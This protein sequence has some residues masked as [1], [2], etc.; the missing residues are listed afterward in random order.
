MMMVPMMMPPQPPMSPGGYPNPMSPQNCGGP[1][2]PGM[3]MVMVPMQMPM[4]QCM[5][6]NGM[7]CAPQTPGPG[8]PM[9]CPMSP[10]DRYTQ[11]ILNADGE[12]F[13][14]GYSPCGDK[15]AGRA[16]FS[17]ASTDTPHSNDTT[18][19]RVHSLSSQSMSD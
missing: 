10:M 13:D 6:R 4:E 16:G 11:D 18:H 1:G 8:S 7:Q 12:C 3:G 17:D 5:M 9:G 14:L 2:Q 19:S 15:F